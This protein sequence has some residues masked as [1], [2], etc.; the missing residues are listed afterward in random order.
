MLSTNKQIIVALF[1][2]VFI[3]LLSGCESN[4]TTNSEYESN[5]LKETVESQEATDDRPMRE[6]GKINTSKLTELIREV[7]KEKG[8]EPSEVRFGGLSD[9]GIVLSGE[10]AWNKY[11]E[12]WKFGAKSFSK[13]NSVTSSDIFNPESPITSFS[14]LPPNPAETQFEVVDISNPP[15]NGSITVQYLGEQVTTN[16]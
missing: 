14:T 10:E 3:L 7:L 4:I 9:K 13:A 5:T 15:A 12:D 11:M 6:P 8:R 16:Y 2:G 1:L